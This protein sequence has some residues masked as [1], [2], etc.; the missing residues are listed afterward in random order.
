MDQSKLYEFEMLKQQ[1]QQIQQH[2]QQF[3]MEVQESEGT[4]QALKEME[5]GK[6]QEAIIS[7]GTGIITKAKISKDEKVMLS[8]GANI[9]VEKTKEEAI[10]YLEKNISEG[11]DAISKLDANLLELDNKL[12]NL[13]EELQKQYM[14]EQIET[15]KKK[16]SDDCEC[17][18]D[19]SNDCEH[20]DCGH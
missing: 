15:Q 5:N 16:H 14:S 20:C 12:K 6:E 3:E 11:M 2:R 8:V 13:A 17:D 18:D 10:K 19:C 1:A 7:L 4:L 9:V